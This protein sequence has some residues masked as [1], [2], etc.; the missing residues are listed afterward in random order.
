[1]GVTFAL[2]PRDPAALEQYAIA[3]STP[4]SSIY[5]Q[6]LTPQQFAQRF[7]PTAAQ[8]KDV[9]RSLRAHGL[10]PGPPSANGLSLHVTATAQTV[11]RALEVTLER[12]AR[13][14]NRTAIA[15]R[16]A[17]ALDAGISHL[18]QAVVGLNS[19][20]GRKP[21]LVRPT[22][23][24]QRQAHDHPDIRRQIAT[25]GPQPCSAASQAAPGQHAYTSDQLASAYNFSGLYGAGDQGQGQTIALYELEPNDPSDIAAFQSCYGTH[26]NVSYLPIDGGAGVGPGTGE[27][28]L[29][30]EAVIGLAPR[31]NF[32]VY[33]GPNSASGEPGAGP[34]DVLSAI[35]SDDRAQVISAS[36]GQCEA[37]E[38][39]GNA[40]AEATLFEE[41]A[42]QGQTFVS[43]SG[44]DGSEDCYAGQLFGATGLAVDDP[45]SQQFVTG[46][47][48]TSLAALGPRPT[49]TVWN[50]GGN[51]L[52]AGSASGA[53]GGG[54]SD[55]WQMPAYQA[56]TPASLNVNRISTS[57]CGGVCRQ[58][59]D[60][61]ADADPG[62]GFE[63]YWN[64]S[65]S[66]NGPVGWQ[67]IGGTSLA[68][69]IWAAM[70]ALANA[71]TAC[72]GT[73]VG[74][75]NPALYAAAATAYATD[76][77]D[78]SSGDNDFTGTNQSRY[79]AGAGFDMASGL[80][81]P[82]AGALTPTLC[83][84]SLRFAPIGPRSS[85]VDSAVSIQPT[86]TGPGTIRY[87]ASG[88]PDGT[89]IDAS[90]GRIAGTP[91][92]IGVYTV[93]IQAVTSDGAVARTSFQWTIGGPPTVSH[94][95]LTGV[96]R[97]RPRLALT[98]HAGQGAPSMTT[99][100][101]TLPRGLKFGG[102][103]RKVV[104]VGR[105]PFTARIS[106]GRLSVTL[107]APSESVGLTISS[108]TLTVSRSLVRAVARHRAKRITLHVTTT[109][110]LGNVTT[111]SFRVRPSR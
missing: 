71:S 85:T 68:A 4:G 24:Q 54:L 94:A 43:A 31:A 23:S 3:V 108:R 57:A 74:F 25:G 102:R 76:F 5:R 98:L 48:G 59:P 82:D 11:D 16:T 77:N 12:F 67:G 50:A 53:G 35:I 9:E 93:T 107:K 7:G 101:I 73:R 95:S 60:I 86:A 15:A 109:D 106:H 29:D 100:V 30:I 36:W 52:K 2:A 20:T 14:G 40:R 44:D 34:Y 63:I 79:A 13:P 78:V 65:R 91:D 28:A 83:A 75:A 38:G 62:T 66:G 42:A 10:S 99:F 61:S 41:A 64:G 92:R 103:A 96:R 37:A 89:F 58:V 88:L 111:V 18:V 87:G 90:T 104:L 26:A 6:Y 22:P 55:L 33:Q 21:L 1:M 105:V 80:G 72:S 19:L 8:M 56:G 45:A 32:L 47:G 69:P 39:P 46:V 17:P 110:L 49:E 81:T 84:D 70:L 97:N 51:V 27:A